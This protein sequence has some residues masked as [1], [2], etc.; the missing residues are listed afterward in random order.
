MSRLIQASAKHRI[1]AKKS[2]KSGG[3]GNFSRF[4]P[5]VEL[6]HTA[7]AY[8]KNFKNKKIN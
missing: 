7:R 5:V 3:Y 6:P 8:N 2:Q 4:L 1:S